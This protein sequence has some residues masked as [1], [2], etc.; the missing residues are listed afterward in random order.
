[1][2]Q[3]SLDT[4]TREDVH[5]ESN[6][7]AHDTRH[8]I[9]QFMNGNNNKSLETRLDTHR[10][11]N[12]TCG[13]GINGKLTINHSVPSVQTNG[14]LQDKTLQNNQSPSTASASSSS[15]IAILRRHTMYDSLIL[16]KQHKP[17]LDGYSLELPNSATISDKRDCAE[18]RPDGC[19]KTK[20]VTVYL[21][22]DDP[23]YQR[24]EEENKNCR[25]KMDGEMVYVPINGLL[26]RLDNYERR[27]I[28]VDSRV[29][30]FA[31]GL[32][33]AERFLTNSSM[34][35]VQEAPPI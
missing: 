8:D 28:A 21:D 22:G 34:K 18:Q 19:C 17:S 12:T 15:T 9:A 14:T 16:V 23:I 4:M 35:E 1:M 31:M 20:L 10:P 29:Y 25:S 26:D 30:A 33:T 5:L 11:T 27:G 6:D 13:A 32:K 3:D 24:Q 2:K 7:T